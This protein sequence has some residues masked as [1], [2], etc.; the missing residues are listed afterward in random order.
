MLHVWGIWTSLLRYLNHDAVFLD[1]RML[2]AMMTA[3]SL[4][5]GDFP[6]S[7]VPLFQCQ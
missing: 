1:G 7:C 3:A 2:I 4:L 6:V 5:H